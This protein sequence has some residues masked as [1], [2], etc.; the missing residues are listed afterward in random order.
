[1]TKHVEQSPQGRR[2]DR[3]TD[4]CAGVANFQTASQA[5]RWA[6]GYRAHHVVAEVLL[7]LEDEF[8]SIGLDALHGGT[9]GRLAVVARADHGAQVHFEGPINF[10]QVL[11]WKMNVHHGSDDLRNSARGGRRRRVW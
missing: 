7:H 2:A 8:A 5:V 10:G 6:H 9:V 3:H 1:F 4:R 11:W